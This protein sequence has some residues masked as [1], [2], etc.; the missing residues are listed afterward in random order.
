MEELFSKC[1]DLVDIRIILYT[2]PNIL[3]YID[4]KTMTNY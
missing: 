4:L 1:H 3:D 2:N